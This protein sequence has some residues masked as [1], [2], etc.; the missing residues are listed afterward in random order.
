MLETQILALR[1]IEISDDRELLAAWQKVA[2][3]FHDRPE[4]LVALADHVEYDDPAWAIESLRKAQA[5]EFNEFVLLNL[6]ELLEQNGKHDQV[7]HEIEHAFAD[8]DSVE[9]VADQLSE[10]LAA[11]QA[12]RRGGAVAVHG[13][14]PPQT[15]AKPASVGVIAVAV[16]LIV[17]ALALILL[18]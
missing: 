2:D 18:L 1:A 4:P 16:L 5:R 10:K 17:L 9:L 15:L 8:P 11:A 12:K 7:I 3:D 14:Q 13:K 6:I